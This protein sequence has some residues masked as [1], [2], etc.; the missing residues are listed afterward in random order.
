[1][2]PEQ[3][4]MQAGPLLGAGG[5]LAIDRV[6]TH[7]DGSA[8]TVIRCQWRSESV[9]VKAANA[10]GSGLPTEQAA[11]RFLGSIPETE[12]WV[13]R[14]IAASEQMIVMTDLGTDQN[15][16]ATILEGDDFMRSKRALQAFVKRLA[17]LHGVTLSHRNAWQPPAGRSR[18]RVHNLHHFLLDFP[19]VFQLVG[20]RPPDSLQSELEHAAYHLLEPGPFLSFAHGDGTAANALVEPSG[21]VKLYDFEAAGYR[22]VL[23][24]GSFPVLRSIH[25]VYAR[26]IPKRMRQDLAATYRRELARWIPAADEGRIYYP[27]LV[28]CAAGWLSGLVANLDKQMESDLRWG[29]STFR[30]R[31][32][33]ALRQFVEL[34]TETGYMTALAEACY[35]L[36]EVLTAAW[37]RMEMETYTS[38]Q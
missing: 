18:H 22:S 25:S 1:M 15:L 28:A 27:C 17:Q 38:L 37:G 21:E 19:R 2:S 23:T 20:V 9:I 4:A 26:Q 16:L 7:Y 35:D 33:D 8:C 6:I 29:M 10:D 12:G 13:P 31:S 14:L 32:Q 36:L 3:A 5:G 30:E 24:D 11:L 34:S